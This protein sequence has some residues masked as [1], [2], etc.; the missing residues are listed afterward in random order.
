MP[1]PPAPRVPRSRYSPNLSGAAV[2]TACSKSKLCRS[3]SASCNAAACSRWSARNASTAA[4]PPVSCARKAAVISSSSVSRALGLW[5]PS[6]TASW[7]RQGRA[8]L[9]AD[10]RLAKSMAAARPSGAIRAVGYH[11]TASPGDHGGPLLL[12]SR[13]MSESSLPLVTR[14]QGKD[15][16]AIEALLVRHLPGLQGWLRLRMGAMLRA[17]DAGGSRAVGGARSA[18]R[19]GRL[20]NGAARRHSAIGCA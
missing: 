8:G 4:A 14:A 20:P 19:P 9:P 18:R 2:L 12:S 1:M 15:A 3:A 17:R 5:W 7:W 11:C 16:A 13:P 10:G 6:L